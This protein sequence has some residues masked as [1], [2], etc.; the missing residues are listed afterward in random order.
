MRR[1]STLFL[2]LLSF[3]FTAV[4]A[5]TTQY[6]SV[7]SG[8]WESGTTW[9]LST[10]GTTWTAASGSP[11][12]A[13]DV[14]V[15]SPHTVTLTGSGRNA[16]NLTIES[17]ATLKSSN[18][19]DYSL[20][21]NGT[22]FLNNGT[23]GG[24]GGERIVLEL[25]T[26]GV[27]FT[28][29]GSGTAQIV[30]FRMS[31]GN[32]NNPVVTFDQNITFTQS[33]NY[34]LTAVY[35]PTATDNYTITIAAGKTVTISNATGYF[36]SSSQGSG[37]GF[38]TYTYNIN[39]TLDNSANLGTT[40][41]TTFQ[42]L[43][44][45]STLNLNISGLYK[46]GTFNTSAN[47]GATG[48]A[49]IT[50]KTG[51]TLEAVA[52]GTYSFA[53]EVPV[54]TE[55]TGKFVRNVAATDAVFPV[56]AGTSYNPAILNNAGTADNF[57]VTVK[58]TIDNA[59]TDATKVVNRQWT[60]NEQAAGG[61]NV[62]LKLGW[63][64]ADQASGFNPAN[65][66]VI[67][68]WTGAAWQSTTATV[69]G[70]GTVADPYIA[71]ASG[72]TAFSP[73]IVANAAALPVTFTAARAYGKGRG[74]QVEW[75]TV[76]ESGVAQYLVER[77]VNGRDFAAVAQVAV[78]T[79]NI[80][81]K[82]YGWFDATPVVGI[83]YYRVKATDLDGS[84]K[85]SSVFQVNIA[86]DKTLVATI[87]NPIRNGEL[88]LQLAGLPKGTYQLRLF[89]AAGQAIFSSQLIADGTV[90]NKSYTLPAAGKSGVVTLQL[91]G[92]GINFN[93]QLI[94]E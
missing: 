39:G 93:R 47:S 90:L 53:A 45:T 5:Q 21:I 18:A 49:N 32:T 75:L 71:T 69:T 43:G 92:N 41:T 19:G 11:G 63:L 94:I 80:A 81:T 78:N 87:A 27:G 2:F 52:G 67:A 62:T 4:M 16:K 26:T 24:A 79:A 56:G 50:I 22:T 72:F 46:T 64:A 20:R 33:A 74:V 59:V 83:N 60:I 15:R 66:V 14:T 82:S 3:S 9:E 65:P 8:N 12:S 51:G 1:I 55:G 61:S 28:L 91:V 7:A 89:N 76:T 58:A 44:G 73:F 13:N 68:R 54:K 57:E 30:R 48:T 17:G 88:N 37:T 36:H 86:N 42:P 38:G 29:S 70:A 34:A 77:S 84:A 85:Y 25:P 10:D 40:N 6:R 23:F 31:G 35:N